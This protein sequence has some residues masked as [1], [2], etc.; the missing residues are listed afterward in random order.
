MVPR[1]EEEQACRA[2]LVERGVA[3][4]AVLLVDP[5]DQ[6]APPPPPGRW[7]IATYGETFVVGA[8]GRGVFRAYE[9]V[10]TLADA[11]DLACRLLT[12]ST[13]ASVEVA[14]DAALAMGAATAHGIR[15]RCAARGQGQPTEVAVGELL[16][17]VGPETEHHVFAYGTSFP[18]RA[19]PPSDA[20]LAWRAYRVARPLPA[21]CLEGSAAPWFGQPGGGAMVVLGRPIRWYVDHGLLVPIAQ[22]S[23]RNG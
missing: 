6:H 7:L 9:Q 10:F 4:D 19:Q 15:Q 16:D 11:V 13:V 2:A 17:C 20:G 22:P 3:A 23:N 12:P 8:M 14:P 5:M 21:D 18:E 1:I